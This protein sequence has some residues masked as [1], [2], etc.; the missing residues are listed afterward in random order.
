MKSITGLFLATVITVPAA[1]AGIYKCVVNGKT[2][3]SQRPCGDES[4]EMDIKVRDVSPSATKERTA[5]N[6][7]KVET[8][9]LDR[10]IRE[11]EREIEKYG[12]QRDREMAR[13]K[14]KKSYAANNLAGATWEQSISTEMRAISDKYDSKIRAAERELERLQSKRGNIN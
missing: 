11:K 8:V 14:K 2:S 4:V 12:K 10:K 5:A 9:L 1:H 3:F 13:L 7:K 6:R